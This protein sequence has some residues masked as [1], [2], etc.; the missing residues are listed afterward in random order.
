MG[1]GNSCAN[2]TRP[3][4]SKFFFFSMVMDSDDRILEKKCSGKSL[5][6]WQAV[7]HSFSSSTKIMDY[8]IVGFNTD[9]TLEF[10]GKKDH[11]K[12]YVTF[13]T[14]FTV[15]ICSFWYSPSLLSTLDYTYSIHI[16]KWHTTYN[17]PSTSAVLQGKGSA[18]C[19]PLFIFAWYL[20]IGTVIT[21]LKA[22]SILKSWCLE[23][24]I[25]KVYRNKYKKQ[26]Q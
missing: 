2:H 9:S 14:V 20:V 12:C 8:I 13:P 22:E 26:L 23:P 4:A 6:G 21:V 25:Q 10:Y 19:C 15:G 16:H 7:F 11:A 24:K 17:V 1:W 18:L 3:G 5:T